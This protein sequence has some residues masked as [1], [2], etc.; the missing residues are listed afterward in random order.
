[1]LEN[2]KHRYNVELPIE[3]LSLDVMPKNGQPMSLFG[4]VGVE[5]VHF[6]TEDVSAFFSGNI[7]EISKPTADFQN[8]SCGHSKS[9][10]ADEEVR[11]VPRLLDARVDQPLGKASIS[12]NEWGSIRER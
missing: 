9:G 1:M 3:R 8:A 6:H 7:K 10:A 12:T 2:M 11:R 4:E 5:A